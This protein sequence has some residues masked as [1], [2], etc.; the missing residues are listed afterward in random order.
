VNLGLEGKAAIV[1][2]GSQGIGRAITLELAAEGAD[3]VSVARGAG[4][5]A[6]TVELAHSSPGRVHALSQ[7]CSLRE[8][9]ARAVVETLEVFGRLDILVNNVGVGARLRIAGS[10]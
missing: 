7:D 6:E 9:A 2:G 10:P 4:P 1:T 5:L 8:A 3:V